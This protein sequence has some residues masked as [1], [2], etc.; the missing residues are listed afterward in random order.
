MDDRKQQ[1]KLNNRGLTLVELNCSHCH[2]W[3]IWSGDSLI[4]YI[5]YE[6]LQACI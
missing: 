1:L 2:Y 4:Y 6:F 5:R 3:H